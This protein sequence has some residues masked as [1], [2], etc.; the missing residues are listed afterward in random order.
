M[1][2]TEQ[3]HLTEA[4]DARFRT[5][6]ER[7]LAIEATSLK[8]AMDEASDLIASAL[9]AEKVDIFIK[10]EKETLIATG[11][12]N[13]PLARKQKAVGLD[14]LP[15]ANGGRFGEVYQTGRPYL[16]GAVDQDEG[17][18]LGVRQTLAI[19]SQMVVPLDLRSAGRGVL[20][21]SCTEPDAFSDDDLRF[22]QAVAHWLGMVAHR[23]ELVERLRRETMEE[24]RRLAAEQLITV[25]AHDLGNYL[26]PLIGRAAIL[27][28]RAEREGRTAD[29]YDAQAMTRSLSRLRKLITNLLDVARLDQGLLQLSRQPVNLVAVVRETA[30]MFQ[31]P[32]STIELSAPDEVIA[33]VDPDRFRQVLENLLTNAIKHGPPGLPIRVNIRSEQGF[34]E[35]T[36][37]DEGP[38]IPPEIHSRIFERFVAGHRSKGLG[39]GLYLARSIAEAHGGSLTVESAAGTGTAFRLR[40]PLL[41]MSGDDDD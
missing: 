36:V 35:V 29:V 20:G 21:V 16:N 28:D 32:S 6:L 22:L 13:T 5:T 1:S 30:Q 3:E 4:R 24:A 23:A 38:G 15:I 41:S 26:T 18:L 33:E 14:R 31:T 34:A 9:D 27:H 39:L 11:T 17:E 7:L 40:I 12:S 2:D 10:D 37:M 25:L 19:H 8:T